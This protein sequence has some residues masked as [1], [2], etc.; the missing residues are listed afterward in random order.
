MRLYITTRARMPSSAV[1]VLLAPQFAISLL[2]WVQLTLSLNRY[3]GVRALTVQDMWALL[4]FAEAGLVRWVAVLSMRSATFA[5]QIV[6]GIVGATLG[7]TSF[8]IV[9]NRGFVLPTRQQVVALGMSVVIT[10]LWEVN[11]RLYL[12]M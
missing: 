1:Y 6:V 12:E 9:F 5:F 7:W 11:N 2:S 3:E 8:V 4:V 10:V